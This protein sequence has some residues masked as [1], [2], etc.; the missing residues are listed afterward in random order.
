MDTPVP[1][2]RPR[3]EI[4]ARLP[5]SA[6]ES[7]RSYEIM[8][9]LLEAAE[10]LQHIHPAVSIYGSSRIPPG[11]PWY[12]LTE[13]IAKRLSDLG[14]AIISGGGPGIMEAANKGGSEGH[15]P[16]VGLNIKLPR[17]QVHNPYQ[18][19][20]LQFQ[21]FFVRKLMF[22]QF[23]SAFIAMPGGLG[24]LDEVMETLNLMQTGKTRRIP[25]ILV[26][27]PFWR[28]M[29]A[30]MRNTLL[31]AG[32]IEQEDFD[33]ITVVNTP[34]EVVDVVIRHCEGSGT[35][36]HPRSPKPKAHHP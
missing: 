30:W 15:S 23:A 9:E 5:W 7:W 34:G 3:E 36:I 1:K 28:D 26:H 22:V 18:D 21:H 14:L 29:L 13:D 32:T 11:H 27:E 33:L 35:P 31:S 10:R 2:V 25:I 17:E 4:D 24:T 16:S 8:S 20:S 6:I 12:Q 19:L